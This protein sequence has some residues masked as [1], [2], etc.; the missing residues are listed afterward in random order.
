MTESVL[1]VT[2]L[3]KEFDVTRGLV[4]RLRGGRRI[5]KAVTG[6]NLSIPTGETL[7]LVGESGSGK[8]T[9][10][11]TVIRLY[12]PDRGSILFEGQDLAPLSGAA[13]R[14]IRRR[15]QMIFQDP[16]SSLNRR[17][18]VEQILTLPLAV[19]RIG[20]RSERGDRVA[21]ALE[22]VGLN[23]SYGHRYPHEFSGGQRQRIGIARALITGP[24]LIVA[25]E[26]VSALDV[27]TQ[28]QIVNLLTR[29]QGEL[30]V[31]YLF[32]SHDL[33][34]VRHISR[35]VAVM[36]LGEIVESGP[37]EEVMKRPAHPYTKSLLSAVPSLHRPK[38]GTRTILGG[39]VPGPVDPPPGCRFHT[40]CP[41][42]IGE[43]CRTVVPRPVEV[44]SGQTVRCH[45]F[46]PQIAK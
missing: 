35:K 27:S 2:D 1:T 42:F 19:H 21:R 17:Q 11:K 4:A 24:S 30:G 7:G 44:G 34:V 46:D 41:A 6:V 37:T 26:P 15:M 10:G 33:S 14:P 23:P 25:D 8:T 5:A 9:V 40:R 20:D 28:A 31:G 3:D 18:T 36:Y 32:I 39:E 16:E 13:V 45:L 38:S 22:Q 12:E 29:L 43:V